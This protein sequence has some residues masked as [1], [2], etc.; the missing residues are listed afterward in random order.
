M[1]EADTLMIIRKSQMRYVFV[2]QLHETG[3]CSN[4]AAK[5]LST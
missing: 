3:Q 1:L 2:T 4:A 5:Q